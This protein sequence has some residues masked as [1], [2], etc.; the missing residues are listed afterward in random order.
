MFV[1][2]AGAKYIGYTVQ[3]LDRFVPNQDPASI[4]YF[5]RRAALG[6]A[7]G[8][9]LLG[10]TANAIN[11]L[12][13]MI[14]PVLHK[15]VWTGRRF[16]QIL[17]VL[18][19]G[20]LLYGLARQAIATGFIIAEGLDLPAAMSRASKPHTYVSAFT[21]IPAFVVN[22]SLEVCTFVYFQRLSATMK[23][24]QRSHFHLLRKALRTMPT[25]SPSQGL[26]VRTMNVLEVDL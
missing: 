16:K 17:V 6:F 9:L 20:A 22:V 4:D 19:V 18:Y 21:N 1:Q 13:A 8:F 12:T 11:R 5:I 23:N 14:F 25:P 7:H 10:D 2:Q 26:D 15:K 3:I 24:Q